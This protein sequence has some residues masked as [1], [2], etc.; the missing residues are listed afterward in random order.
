MRKLV[1]L[2]FCV[3]LGCGLVFFT[4]AAAMAATIPINLVDGNWQNWTGGS[5]IE[6]D[7]SLD[8]V[9]TIRWGTCAG[10][11][12]WDFD[13][14]GYIFD[15]SDFVPIDAP[16]DGSYFPLGNFYHLNYPIRSNTAITAVDLNVILGDEITASATFAYT[17]NET[18]NTGSGNC[19]N[20]IVT[21]TNPVVDQFFQ[22][23]GKDYYFNMIGF[24][25]DG[26][27]NIA[28]VFSTVEG[29]SNMATLYGMITDYRIGEEA[30][31][32]IPEPATML[33]L[34]TGLV[35]IAGAARRRKKKEA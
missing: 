3:V 29:Q 7:N 30:P 12:C 26:G 19:C 4:T 18:T 27:K 15:S 32:P 22:Y 34:G 11:F 14:S 24:S 23:L 35:G 6:V 5:G 28:N 10:L 17:H 20:D 2:F 25:T 16:T 9:G 21:L 13:K 31:E 8:T 1:K 33:L